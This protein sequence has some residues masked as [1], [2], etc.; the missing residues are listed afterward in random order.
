[1]EKPDPLAVKSMAH[2]AMLRALLKTMPQENFD[3]FSEYLLKLWAD[4]AIHNQ[5]EEIRPALSAARE[6]CE[7]IVA[8]AKLER[9]R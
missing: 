8:T 4:I 1:M 2:D 5:A 3:A 9:S 6:S 7:S